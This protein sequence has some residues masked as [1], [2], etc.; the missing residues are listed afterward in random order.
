[1]WLVWKRAHSSNFGRFI[2]LVAV[3]HAARLGTSLKVTR[4]IFFTN[5]ALLRD[6]VDFLITLGVLQLF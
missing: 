4:L 3:F 1:M 2:V 6:I 5:T